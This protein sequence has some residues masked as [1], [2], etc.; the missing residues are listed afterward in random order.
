MRQDKWDNLGPWDKRSQII[1]HWSL[2]FSRYSRCFGCDLFTK[3]CRFISRPIIFNES[4]LLSKWCRLEPFIWISC[5]KHDKIIL[6]MHWPH[7]R[8]FDFGQF[9]LAVF[10]NFSARK[11]WQ[12]WQ[13]LL[14][15]W[16]TFVSQYFEWSKLC[17]VFFYIQKDFAFVVKIF[18][19][20]FCHLCWNYW[21]NI[22]LLKRVES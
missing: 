7:W 17:L 6:L 14:Q 10:W 22:R 8:N 9:F 18:E 19:T 3:T 1:R 4:C 13:N 16:K 2:N 11:K 5:N 12:N 21:R 20:K 15:I